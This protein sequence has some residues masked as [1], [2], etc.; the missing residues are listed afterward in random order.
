MRKASFTVNRIYLISLIC[1]CLAVLA[2]PALA[3]VLTITDVFISYG[4]GSVT[5]ANDGSWATF[6]GT[7]SGAPISY[8]GQIDVTSLALIGIDNLSYHCSSAAGPCGSNPGIWF[9][10]HGSGFAPQTSFTLALSGSA[11][12]TASGDFRAEV[13]HGDPSWSDNMTNLGNIHFDA[14]SGPLT[15]NGPL[16]TLVDLARSP[17]PGE[18][19]TA[20]VGDFELQAWF[21]I[22]NLSAGGTVSWGETSA[23]VHI[24]QSADDQVPE[25]A[26]AA[27]FAGGL[28]ALALWRLKRRG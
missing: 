9:K 20:P 16:T 4:N 27:L 2:G 21:G 13:F 3:G 8:A 19:A 7:G 10:A 26:S 24:A 1:A 12:G 17:N 28:A 15:N 22:T 11:S 18:G 25:P 6:S 5:M 14:N 23:D